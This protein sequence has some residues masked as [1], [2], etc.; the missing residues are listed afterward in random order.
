MLSVKMEKLGFV[1]DYNTVSP[2]SRK[3][4]LFRVTPII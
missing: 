3:P 1:I 4:I 2:H